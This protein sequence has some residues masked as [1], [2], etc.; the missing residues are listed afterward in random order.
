[1]PESTVNESD[2]RRLVLEV[3]S[4]VPTDDWG[5]I[6]SEVLKRANA[7]GLGSMG[8]SSEQRINQAI[9]A[10]II[11]QLVTVGARDGNYS[12][13]WPS[14]ILTELGRNWA[15]DS[16][17]LRDPDGYGQLLKEYAPGLQEATIEYALEPIPKPL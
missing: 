3:L 13:N 1:M 12:P 10:L 11:E 14:I 16:T 8:R 5:S 6:R 2:L 9:I 4:S 7:E 15:D 17:R